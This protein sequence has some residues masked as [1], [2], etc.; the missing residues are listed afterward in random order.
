VAEL[1]DPIASAI[2]HRNTASCSAPGTARVLALDVA[3][4]MGW[5]LRTPA[6]ITS[7]SI[8]FDQR[9]RET[10]GDRLLRFDQWLHAMNATQLSL[11]AYEDVAFH[12]KFNGVQTAHTWGQFEGVLLM[13]AARKLIPVVAVG[14]GTVKKHATGKG[15]AT[16]DQVRAAIKARGF[17]PDDDDEA[18]ALAVLGWALEGRK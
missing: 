17:T 11:I 18:D 9:K 1:V 14:V 15:N 2:G 12:G 5:A 7:G 13:F 6:C 4:S 16:K 10:R 8:S 3:T